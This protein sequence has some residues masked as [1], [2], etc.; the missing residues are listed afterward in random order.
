MTRFTIQIITILFSFFLLS[1]EA[2]ADTMYVNDNM[3]ITFRA[4]PG[5]DHKIMALLSVG[6]RVEV[7]SPGE[8]WTQVQ[9][10][11]GKEGWVL[12]R[13]L[14]TDIPCDMEM[15]DLKNAYQRINKTA[16]ALKDENLT[17]KT[18][19]KT[20]SEDLK[21]R[22]QALDTVQ[23]QFDTLQKESANFLELKTKYEKAVTELSAQTKRADELD[24]S[25]SAAL[26][27][28]QIKWFIGGA[29][30]LLLGMI[31]GFSSKR[32]K[33]KSSLY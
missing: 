9:L 1:I 17:L 6:E 11:D 7:I 26:K 22:Q 10:S 24:R 29:G 14:T 5:N 23:T 3:K 16:A 25:L 8:D 27:S 15:K 19:L 4:G 21:Q 13:Y 32:E 28:R 20:V 33:R 2:Y 12:T 18:E 31:L 30:T